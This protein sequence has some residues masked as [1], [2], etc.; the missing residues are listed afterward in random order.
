MSDV[1]YCRQV[2]VEYEQIKQA[3][4]GK[5]ATNNNAVTDQATDKTTTKAEESTTGPSD[6]SSQVLTRVERLIEVGRIGRRFVRA[7]S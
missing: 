5:L 7:M 1:D 4:L 2:N 3:I 6:L